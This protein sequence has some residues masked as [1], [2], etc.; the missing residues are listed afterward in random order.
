MK[1]DQDD[2]LPYLIITINFLLTTALIMM[3]FIYSSHACADPGSV[4]IGG[5]DNS[6][7][8]KDVQNLMT[9]IQN[10]GFKWV[11]KIIGGFLVVTGIYK[12][13]SR[14]FMSGILATACGGCLFFVEK[15]VDS[16]AKMGGS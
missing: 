9:T 4:Y 7:Q 15:I 5:T 2:Y 16:L 1:N 3:M 10:I 6:G 14:E 11:A 12:I 8:M 13:A